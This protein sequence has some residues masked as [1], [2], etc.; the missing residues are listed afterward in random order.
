[1]IY[2]DS[3]ARYNSKIHSFPL[4]MFRKLFKLED[5]EMQT[6]VINDDIVSDEELGI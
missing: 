5:Y 3:V 2:S 6:N 1:M 4:V